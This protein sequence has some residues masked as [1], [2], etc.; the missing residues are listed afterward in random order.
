MQCSTKFKKILTLI[1]TFLCI[2]L[3]ALISQNIVEKY[4][5]YF[6]EKSSEKF[7]AYNYF[8]PKA[9]ERKLLHQLP[10]YDWYDLPVND[11]FLNQLAPFVT[12][13][14]CTSRWLNAAVIYTH[15]ENVQ[16]IASL[17]FVSSVEPQNSAFFIG[18]I[19]EI[20]DNPIEISRQTERMGIRKFDSLGVN[21]KGILIAIF[22]VGFSGA[23]KHPAFEHIRKSN[24]ILKTFDFVKNIEDVYHGGSHG[25]SVWSCIAGKKDS[26]A[27]GLATE[28]NFLLARTEIISKEILAEEENWV[29]AAEWAHKNGADIINSSLGYTHARYFPEN[30]NGKTALISR[31]ASIAAKKGILVINAA[32]ND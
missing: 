9:I 11:E 25:T 14:K 5:V 6:N 4:I 29:M 23:D 32:G 26:I 16:K 27:L 15:L 13:L 24:R 31:G 8:T 28:A 7:D 22:D 17:P 21:G 30:M 20:N 19:T 1:I 3:N 2:N 12:K 18:E 10:L